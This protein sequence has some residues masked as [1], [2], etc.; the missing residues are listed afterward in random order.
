MPLWNRYTRAKGGDNLNTSES[1]KAVCRSIIDEC[2]AICKYTDDM[3][4]INEDPVT[5]AVLAENRLDEL[6]HVQKLAVQLTKLMIPAESAETGE[7]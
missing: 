6:E 7:T 3:A 4:L 1:V 5:L 2:E